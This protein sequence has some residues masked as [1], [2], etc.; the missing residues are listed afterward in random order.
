MRKGRVAARGEL[1]TRRLVW[2]R[3]QASLTCGSCPRRTS[4]AVV[5]SVS[6]RNACGHVGKHTRGKGG[7]SGP[8]SGDGSPASLCDQLR[9]HELDTSRDTSC[10]QVRGAV[11]ARFRGALASSRAKSSTLWPSPPPASSMAASPPSS[12]A[13]TKSWA[14]ATSMGAGSCGGHW[15]WQH[16]TRGGAAGRQ[17]RT[18]GGAHHRAGCGTRAH[19]GP[20]TGSGTATW[21]PLRH[22][23]SG[24]PLDG[25]LAR[26]HGRTHLLAALQAGRRQSQRRS[27]EQPCCRCLCLQPGACPPAPG[28]AGHHAA[29][30]SQRCARLC[31]L[32]PRSSRSC[33]VWSAFGGGLR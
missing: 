7:V 8:C 25:P 21:Q 2:R 17:S 1:T 3:S 30:P 20:A 6:G 31:A 18:R 32:Q 27:P 9:R 11:R 19:S 22:P 4:C 12:S 29:R 10:A 24:A 33:G 23:H 28:G 15:G 5:A 14:A 16:D 26:C 13:N